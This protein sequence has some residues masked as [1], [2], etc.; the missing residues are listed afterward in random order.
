MADL[1]IYRESLGGHE[2]RLLGTSR[3][4]KSEDYWEFDTTGGLRL[5]IRHVSSGEHHVYLVKGK[6]GYYRPQPL[7]GEFL[8][9][10]SAPSDGGPHFL[11]EP[12]KAQS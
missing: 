10:R 5:G 4:G 7:I 1:I 6:A 2:I 12:A 9:L 8:K 3:I 11:L